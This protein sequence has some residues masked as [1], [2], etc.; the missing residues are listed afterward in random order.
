MK[1]GVGVFRCAILTLALLPFSASAQEGKVR[2]KHTYPNLYVADAVSV[3]EEATAAVNGEDY[4]KGPDH[5]DVSRDLVFGP[6]SYLML[7]AQ[8]LDLDYRPG[9]EFTDTSFVDLER[10][11]FTEFRDLYLD[12]YL[13]TG[14]LP[15]FQWRLTS[16]SRTYLEYQV[17]KATA[18]IDSAVVEAWFSP[19]I[20]VSAG[21]GLY[22]GLPGLILLLTNPL[23]GEVY[24]AESVELA[25]QPP[26]LPP[27]TGTAV[28]AGEY[29]TLKAAQLEKLRR[30]G[31]DMRQRIEDGRLIFQRRDF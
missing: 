9:L 15:R 1:L 21:P 26:I 5:S 24:A 8:E 7:P 28:S 30:G 29:E 4:S 22:G 13:V 3:F 12:T 19:D 23:T 11:T 31:E 27:R 20:P 14:E 6:R 25:E 17:M 2:F 16:E 10:G 18:V